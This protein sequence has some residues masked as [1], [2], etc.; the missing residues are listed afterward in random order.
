MWERSDVCKWLLFI[1]LHR[2]C[3]VLFRR[4]VFLP[5]AAIS[6]IKGWKARQFN[7]GNFYFTSP[8]K[9]RLLR[10]SFNLLAM[11]MVVIF[12]FANSASPVPNTFSDWI[13]VSFL[14]YVRKVSAERDLRVRE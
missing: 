1:L 9:M 12:F 6:L 11:L 7:K 8:F 14:W 3:T 4:F 13:A 2:V 5:V 10:G